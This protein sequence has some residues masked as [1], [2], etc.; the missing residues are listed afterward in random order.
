MKAPPCA[1]VHSSPEPLVGPAISRGRGAADRSLAFP[2]ANGISGRREYACGPI[3]AIPAG[4]S[5]HLSPKES[6]TPIELGTAD[7]APKADFALG[8]FWSA[9]GKKNMRTDRSAHPRGLSASVEYQKCTAGIRPQHVPARI[10]HLPTER[11]LGFGRAVLRSARQRHS[12]GA[13][14]CT[15]RRSD[16]AARRGV[17]PSLAA[18]A[19]RGRPRRLLRRL[20]WRPTGG[21]TLE[22]RFSRGDRLGRIYGSRRRKR[23]SCTDITLVFDHEHDSM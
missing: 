4:G 19:P 1:Y 23:V 7:F 14:R 10:A 20:S 5:R 16:A 8:R 9:A 12:R 18:G 11:R 21:A 13:T 3:L 2:V 22:R 6:E 15:R 17:R